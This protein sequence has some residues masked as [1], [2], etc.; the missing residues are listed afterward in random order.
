MPA[1]RCSIVRI[2][3]VQ[4]ETIDVSSQRIID[5]SDDPRIV[6]HAF[7]DEREWI[8]SSVAAIGDAIVA[9]L[10][11]EYEV[12]LLLSGGS[13]PGPVYRA[14]AEY[15]LDWSRVIVGLA[16]ERDVE[17]D[18]PGSNA[19][20]VSESFLSEFP[21]QGRY[22]Q[23]DC[24][25]TGSARA[26][27]SKHE[28]RED[29]AAVRPSIPQDER[30][31]IA[32]GSFVEAESQDQLIGADHPSTPRDEQAAIIRDP[33][34]VRGEVSNHNSENSVDIPA[35][36]EQSDAG[37]ESPRFRQLRAA[38]QALSAAVA[39]ANRDQAADPK[40]AVIVLGMGDD[41]HTAS[42]FPGARDLD[43]ALASTQP[44]ASIDAAGCAVAGNYPHRITLTRAGLAA[45]R[46]RFLLIRGAT[47][48]VVLERA[49][50]AGDIREFPIRAAI[51][52]PGSALHVYWCRD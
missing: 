48:R 34:S 7:D 20:L 47:K 26:E 42:L 52:V 51:E 25:E 32:P 13:T 3:A 21:A 29:L 8:E 17:P 18:D 28:R 16:D 30:M 41:G 39:A 36:V 12:R 4:T 33:L 19:R 50:Q 44:Y 1:I 31:G 10:A 45:T 6:W 27:V 46:T 49:L 37:H 22:F 35:S 43:A 5:V 24:A 11:V 40:G 15:P 14:L 38:D 23:Q 9:A 2:P